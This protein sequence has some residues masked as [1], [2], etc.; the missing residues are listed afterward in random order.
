TEHVAE[1]RDHRALA[2]WVAHPHAGGELRRVADEPRVGVGGG[3]TGLAGGGP[4]GVG[5]GTGAVAEDTP[6]PLRSRGRGLPARD[7]VSVAAICGLSTGVPLPWSS[8]NTRPSGPTTFVTNM[9]GRRM[10]AFANTEYA[11]VISSTDVGLV[12]SVSDGTALSLLVSMPRR[13][14]ISMT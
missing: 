2:G 12:P 11:P 6:Q 8:N 10:P 5:A 1:H 9:G 3:R 14:A 7:P 4:A 13:P